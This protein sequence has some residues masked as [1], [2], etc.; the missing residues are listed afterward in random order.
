MDSLFPT[1]IRELML[2]M[3]R[4]LLLRLLF[5]LGRR[6][7]DHARRRL[8]GAGRRKSGPAVRGGQRSG[9]A[10][11]HVTYCEY[12]QDRQ[13]E[14]AGRRENLRDAAG[15]VH[16]HEKEHDERRFHASDD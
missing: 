1:M 2:V 6:M 15:V 16:V 14:K 13:P 3:G 5:S 10:H 7:G 8:D 11:L 12:N 4:F 9:S